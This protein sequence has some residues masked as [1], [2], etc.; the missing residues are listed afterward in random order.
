MSIFLKVQLAYKPGFVRLVKQDLTIIYL[1]D[2]TACTW[3]KINTFTVSPSWLLSESNKV[4]PVS[5]L[6]HL[7]CTG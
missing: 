3:Y 4:I 5:T 1:C 6:A 7:S 2:R